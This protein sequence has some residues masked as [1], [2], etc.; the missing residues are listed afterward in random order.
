METSIGN[1]VKNFI[2]L[3]EDDTGFDTLLLTSI[4]NSI[5][6]LKQLG[7]VNLVS[8]SDLNTPLSSI[9]PGLTVANP[10]IR[11]V[12]LKAQKAFDPSPNSVVAQA[13]NDEV[14]ELEFRLSIEGA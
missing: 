11:Y 6:A 1:V 14:K 2:G 5:F 13:L 9:A 12:C 8:P 3:P 4:S 7:C 10:I